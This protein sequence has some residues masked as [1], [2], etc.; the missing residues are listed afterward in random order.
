[1]EKDKQ[2]RTEKNARKTTTNPAQMF[3]QFLILLS[4]NIFSILQL[5]LPLLSQVY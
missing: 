5:V 2:W 3:C 1:M 4:T